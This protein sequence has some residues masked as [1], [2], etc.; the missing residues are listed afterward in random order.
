[1]RVFVAGATGAIGRQLVPMLLARGH[2]VVGMTR[3]PDRAA[4][5]GQ[6]GA[7]PQRCDVYDRPRLEGAL[8]AAQPDVLVHQL[9]AL[10]QK[11]AVRD[12]G[13]NRPTDRIRREGT[14]NLIAAAHAANC[15]RL[16]A[17]SIAFLYRPD[18]ANTLKT[19]TDRPFTDAP[20]PFADT[21]DA[22]LDLEAQVAAADP[23][24]SVVLRYGWLYGPGTWYAPDGYYAGQVRRRRYPI[25][26]NGHGVS[27]F[28]HVADAAAAAADVIESDA[29][30]TFNIVDDDPAPL[31]EWL[32][33]YA[34]ALGAP[35]PRR[36]PAWLARLAA[37]PLAVKMSTRMPGA[38]NAR[39]KREL[40]WR[41][42]HSS[43]R[44]EF[45]DL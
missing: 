22:L 19:E 28:V 24:S 27:S 7:I 2:S 35:S 40:G 3:S 13:I 21:V 29:T 44:E 12:R 17:Q 11:Y 6:L 30:G 5:L 42:T 36:V 9:T 33:A 31:C 23:I 1:M 38:S 32:P 20:Q 34:Q 45:T 16:I 41:P 4:W 25:V 14:R 10:P 37:G 8:K 18:G 26:G 39:A 43:W 15:P